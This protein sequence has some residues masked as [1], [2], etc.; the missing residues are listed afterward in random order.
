MKNN[1]VMSKCSLVTATEEQNW[2]T[3][4]L[5]GHVTE[6]Q[7]ALW[8]YRRP[9]VVLGCSKRP[10]EEMRAY[11]GKID[12]DLVQRRTGGGA[13]LVGPWMMSASIL[14][15]LHH[16]LANLNIHETYRWFGESHA[17]ALRSFGLESEVIKSNKDPLVS[18]DKKLD[19]ACFGGRCTGEL[20]VNNRKVVGLA[21]LRSKRGIL[22]VSGILLYDPNWKLLCNVYGQPEDHAEGLHNETTSCERE[23]GHRVAP[24]NLAQVLASTLVNTIKHPNL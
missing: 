24:K 3:T 7:V 5:K 18:A 14:L 23:L 20:I 10:T 11:S 22:L 2:N 17:V 13:V 19:W 8:E 4:Q 16:P 12:V 1:N 9:G 6:A 21:Q 15:P